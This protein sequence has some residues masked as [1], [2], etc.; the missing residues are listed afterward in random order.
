MIRT[1]SISPRTLMDKRRRRAKDGCVDMNSGSRLLVP[2]DKDIL[3]GAWKGRIHGLRWPVAKVA[4]SPNAIMVRA[5][6]AARQPVDRAHK[7]GI[8]VGPGRNT[9]AS[10]GRRQCE[11]EMR[12]PRSCSASAITAQIDPRLPACVSLSLTVVS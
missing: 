1:S 6:Q 4:G 10:R 9:R 5:F 2:E 7:I 12:L 11:L 8:I 3:F